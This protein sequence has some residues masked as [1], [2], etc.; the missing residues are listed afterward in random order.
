MKLVLR[1]HLRRF[2]RSTEGSNAIEFAI[3]AVPFILLIVGIIQISIYFVAQAALDIGVSK[4]AETLRLA[5]NTSTV[6]SSSFPTSATLKSR[7]ATYA[8]GLINNNS[9][10]AVEIQP[11][12]SLTSAG[13]TIVDATKNYGSNR[14]VLALRAR[15]TVPSFL[16]GFSSW[17]V[18]S[19]ALVRRQGR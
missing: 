15:S 9:S 10:L 12:T 3:L 11:M 16:P 13:V 1:G 6:T 18:T 14:S 8:G 19:S 17:Y 7:V 5:F 4:T 2:A